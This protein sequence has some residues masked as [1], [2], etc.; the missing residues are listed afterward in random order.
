MR[1]LIL[2]LLI[3]LFTNFSLKACDICGCGIS[4][5]PGGIL[6][7]I[8]QQILGLSYS[9]TQ[10]KHQL[11]DES[12]S[13]NGSRVMHDFQHKADLLLRINP[14]RR[15]QVLFQLPYSINYRI[16]DMGSSRIDGIGDI[17]MQYHYHL[18]D[19]VNWIDKKY[20]LT[21]LGGLGIK[22]PTGKYQQRDMHRQMIPNGFQVGSGSWALSAHINSII[23]S[24]KQGLHLE[25]QGQVSTTNEL[26][27]KRGNFYTAGVN[28]FRN[29]SLKKGT[30]I[31]SLGLQYE[32]FDKDLEYRV[33][34]NSTGG[35]FVQ[36]QL[37]IDYLSKKMNLGIFCAIPV[38]NASPYVQPYR[39]VTTGMQAFF[40]L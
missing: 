34:E 16:E 24:K 35:Q 25:L 19:P 18:I 20:K 17:G 37:R 14:N 4:S 21:L 36:T 38:L 29:L 30:L 7:R 9:Y 6:P 3:I 2:L 26:Q 15:S 39:I 1:Q 33:P 10:F 8:N 12:L 5:M 11:V 27:Y 22:M 13:A 32:L 28:Y 40:F 23:A 31:L